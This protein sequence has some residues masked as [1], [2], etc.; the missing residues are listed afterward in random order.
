MRRIKKYS[1]ANSEEALH[2]LVN[3]QIAPAP[4]ARAAFC[5]DALKTA[6]RTGTEQYVIL[7]AGM[8]TFA[9]REQEF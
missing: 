3:T 5:E 7:G 8:D 9:F 6:M 4:L 2:Y 1:F